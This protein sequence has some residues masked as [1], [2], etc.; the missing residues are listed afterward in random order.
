MIKI[1][2]QIPTPR[3]AG[4]RGDGGGPAAVKP[5]G[6]PVSLE[7]GA[8][9]RG[10]V[11]SSGADGRLVLDLAGQRIEARSMVPL[12]PGREFWFEV[13]QGGQEPRLAL[14]DKQG[15]AHRFLQ[16]A[17]GG[18]QELNRLGALLSLLGR[19]LPAAGS[20]TPSPPVGTVAGE[21]DPAALLS[22]L[23]LGPEPEPEKI[24]RLLTMLRGGESALGTRGPLP[25]LAGRLQALVAA[26]GSPP[27]PALPEGDDSAPAASLREALTGLARAGGVLEALVTMNEQP[28]PPGQAPFWL[29]PCF[30]ALDAG[31][32][33]WLLSRGEAG[34]EGE[35]SS[36]LVFFLEMSRLGELQLQVRVR[37]ERLEGD[38]F[39]ADPEAARFLRGRLGELR[40]RLAALGYQSVLRCR[41][42]AKPLLPALKAALEKA[43]G[44]ASLR[45]ID[46]KA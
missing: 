14:A 37:R 7:Q 6:P 25:N 11:V 3:P 30:F 31:A 42:G 22:R 1:G 46:I 33:S 43:A 16:Q 36:S 2:G 18:L 28:P 21:G 41:V 39:L 32:G 8:L 5:A 19:V 26:A 12:S 15:A 23:V 10:R 20:A 27:P 24:V 38:F 45:L 9:L 40:E 35:E 44:S 29:L 13:R 34:E 4:G 17:S